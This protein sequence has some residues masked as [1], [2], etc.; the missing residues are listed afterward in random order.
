MRKLCPKSALTAAFGLCLLAAGCGTVPQ[1]SARA[2]P[3]AHF[4]V[5][6][7]SDCEWQIAIAPASGG[8]H[9]VLHLTARAS[10]AIDLPAGDYAVEQT[11]LTADAGIESARRF[12]SH[13]DAGQTYRW[14]LATLLTAPSGESDGDLTDNGHERKR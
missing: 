3:V 9:R 13:L 14:R 2:G 5:I 1:P 6:N 11:A 7:L 12:T 8:E 4:M 10:Q